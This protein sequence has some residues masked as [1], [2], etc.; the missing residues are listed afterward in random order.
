MEEA[1]VAPVWPVGPVTVEG[2]PVAP[3]W[4]VGPVLPVGPVTPITLSSCVIVKRDRFPAFKIVTG[5]PLSCVYSQRT[6]SPGSRI[7]MAV[8]D[9]AFTESIAVNPNENAL[10]FMNPKMF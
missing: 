7:I 8:A 6:V 3:V 1:P 5:A 2:A 10:F 9:T 4:P